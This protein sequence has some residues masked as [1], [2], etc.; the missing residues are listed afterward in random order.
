[1]HIVWVSLCCGEDTTAVALAVPSLL[2]EHNRVQRGTDN[3]G[4]DSDDNETDDAKLCQPAAHA[5]ELWLGGGGTGQDQVL[6]L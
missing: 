5:S 4:Q 2:A 3:V 1:M 6:L